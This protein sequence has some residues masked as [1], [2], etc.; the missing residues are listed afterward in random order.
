[1]NELFA[2]APQ[3]NPNLQLASLRQGPA[4]D[5]PWLEPKGGRGTTDDSNNRSDKADIKVLVAT[6]RASLQQSHPE[7]DVLYSDSY[8]K[9]VLSVPNRTYEHARDVKILGALNWRRSYNVDALVKAFKCVYDVNGASIFRLADTPVMDKCTDDNK[10][11]SSNSILFQPSQ[12]L[13]G[14][15]ESAAFCFAGFD[16]EGRAILHARTSMLDWWK[17]GVE[18]GIRYH[19]LVIEHTLSVILNRNDSIY[20]A[21]EKEMLKMNKISESMVLYVDTSGMR[22]LSPPP[23]GSIIGMAKLLQIAYPDRIHQ[24]R[25]GPVN[26]LLMKLYEYVLPYLRP[27]SRDKIVLLDHSPYINETEL[28]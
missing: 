25:I 15:C 2:S 20:K 3:P 5:S 14:V 27:R 6:L 18:D 11:N 7:I 1:M 12:Y 26:P 22:L 24:I 10:C 4:V 19:V 21:K 13:V 9:S 16:G 28:R 17:T 8:L 23:L